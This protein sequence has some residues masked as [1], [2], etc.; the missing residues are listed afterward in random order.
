M[1]RPL[2]T[3][4][5]PYHSATADISDVDRDGDAGLPRRDPAGELGDVVGDLGPLF[6]EPLRI[7]CQ[8]RRHP[9]QA[10]GEHVE[11]DGALGRRD[12]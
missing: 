3:W 11:L 12:R 10:R 8:R 5:V 4:L 6:V 9:A 2:M 7:G 1:R